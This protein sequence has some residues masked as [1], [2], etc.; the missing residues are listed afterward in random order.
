MRNA[1]I[2]A[3][4]DELADLYELDGAIVHRVV[5]YRNAARAIRDTARPVGELARAGRAVELPGVGKT[6]QDQVVALLDT[7]EI[8][9]AEKLKKKFPAGL[10][11]I[12]RMP[13]FGPKR[14]R[15]LYEELGIASLE[16]LRH[17]AESHRLREVPGFG[18]K[19]E[20]NVLAAIAAGEDGRP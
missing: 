3:H 8:P 6:I 5:A 11:E 20:E 7:G 1:E 10:V 13:G 9:S 17:A 16:E 4:L 15:K 19:A 14:A 18:E 2:A 12:T